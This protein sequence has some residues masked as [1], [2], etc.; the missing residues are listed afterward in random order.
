MASVPIWRLLTRLLQAGV[1]FS[2]KEKIKDQ[3][4]IVK[5]QHRKGQML[6]VSHYPL[7]FILLSVFSHSGFSHC[8]ETSASFQHLRER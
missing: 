5:L 2:F 3:Q 8:Q 6:L 7:W 1:C 4:D